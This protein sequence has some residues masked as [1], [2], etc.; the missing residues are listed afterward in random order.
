MTR[1]QLILIALIICLS[2]SSK[3]YHVAKT[4]NDNNSGDRNAPFLTIQAAANHAKPGD[5]IMVHEGVYRE[6][7]NPPRGGSSNEKRIVYQAAEGN[8]VEIKGSEEINNWVK[9][10]GTVWKATISNSMFGKYN[11]YKDLIHGDWFDNKGRNH[12]TGEVYLNGKSFWEMDI[13]E[14]VLKSEPI[15]GKWDTQGSIYTWFCESDTENTYIYA[16]FHGYNPNNEL[17]EINVRSTCFYPDST[18]INF[19]TVRNFQLSQAATQWAPPTAEQIGL[20][21]TNWSKGWIIE[22][23]ILRN[24]KCAGITL[25]KYGDQYD[26]TSANAAEGY[27]ETVKRALIKGWNKENIGS[28]SIRNNTISDCEQVGICGSLGGVFSIIEN[29][30]IYNIGTKQQFAGAEMGGIKIHAAI[31]MLIKGNRVVNCGKGIWIDW[32]AQGTRITSN[33]CYNN[34]YQDLYA[35]VNH[36]PYLVDNNLFLSLCSVWDMSQGGAYVHNLMAG[37]LNMSSPHSRITPYHQLHSTQ[38]AGYDSIHG[39]DNRFINNIF[40]AGCQLNENQNNPE[41]ETRAH[42]GKEYFG[43]KAFNHSAF[44]I[45]SKNNVYLKGAFPF[46]NEINGLEL[47]DDP[48]IQITENKDGIFFSMQVNKKIIKVQSNAVTTKL[49][50]ETIISKQAYVNPDNSSIIIDKDFLGN[51]RSKQNPTVGPFE[52]TG[53]GMRKIRV[54]K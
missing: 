16:N 15:P 6:R 3:E 32:M 40:I 35:E 48:N 27:V 26:N 50:G 20:I 5:I 46:E 11:P 14:K 25:G 22:N 28:H 31:D 47:A 49:L 36:G 13:L 53:F 9:F 2:L 10:F 33:L 38:I 29:N 24:S 12:H 4:G 7:I 37:K 21:G 45:L 19:I 39:G 44:P 52:L 41:Y 43:L 23:N 34:N 8:K 1:L 42:Y 30:N 18:N 54:W 51:N 17:V